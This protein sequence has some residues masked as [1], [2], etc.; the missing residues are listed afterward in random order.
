[1]ESKAPVPPEVR[2]AML[3]GDETALSSMGRAGARAA[4]KSRAIEKAHQEFE[5]EERL[6]GAQANAD[7]RRDHLIEDL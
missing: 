4:A 6:E 7:A 3:R 1:M 2:E 5:R